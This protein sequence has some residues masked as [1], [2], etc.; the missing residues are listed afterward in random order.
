MFDFTTGEKKDSSTRD[1]VK[2]IRSLYDL[3]SYLQYIIE[4]YPWSFMGFILLTMI[5]PKIYELTNTYWIGQIDNSALAITEQY[6]FLVIFTEFINESIPCGILVLISQN[7][8]NK[9]QIAVILKSGIVLQIFFSTLIMF[10]IILFTPQF[11][12]AIGTPPEIVS[13]TKQYLILKSIALPFDAVAFLILLSI[14][15]LKKGKDAFCIIVFSV[16]LNMGFDLILVSNFDFSLQLGIHGVAMGYVISKIILAIFSMGYICYKLNITI[17]DI[18]MEN[19]FRHFKTIISIGGFSGLGSIMMNIGYFIT[20]IILNLIGAD[21]FGGYGLSMILMWTAIIPVLAL[22]EGTNVTVGNFIGEKRYNDINRIIQTSI[23]LAVGIMLIIGI[24][25]I[26]L[27]DNLSAMMN[28][29]PSI[30]NYSTQAFWWLIIPYIFFSI[31][32]VMKSLFFGTGQT[33]YIMYTSL[34]VNIIVVVP[35]VFFVMENIIEA[36]F[37][38]VM[39]QLFVVYGMDLFIVL[40]YVRN[41]KINRSNSRNLQITIG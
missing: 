39:V 11:V 14:K 21:T 37:T 16:I 23:I 1:N 17:K 32:T 6:E 4:P 19:N 31:S 38:N 34:I 18:I 22:A 27:W 2:N 35:F 25:G 13:L 36:T 30:V 29:N 28:M 10:F 9:D 40:T 7:Y 20:L 26:F 3:K 33:K 15:S 8:K 41:L 5:I 24:G 12:S